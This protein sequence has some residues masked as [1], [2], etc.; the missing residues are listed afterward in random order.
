MANDMVVKVG[1]SLFDLPDLGSRLRAWLTGQPTR[2]MVLVPGG[3]AAAD[4]VRMAAVSDALHETTC[5]WLALSAMEFMGHILLA[6]LQLRGALIEDIAGRED[7]WRQGLIPVLGMYGFASK[8][9]LS[10]DHLPHSWAATSDSFAARAAVVAD[11]PELVLL[12]SCDLP[13]GCD[14]VEAARRGIVDALFPDLLAKAGARLRATVVN[15]RQWSAPA[16]SAIVPPGN[17][18]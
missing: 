16:S 7:A 3:G 11:I 14:W 5:H 9:E 10:S 12:K 17:T 1:G 13:T 2:R 6:R 18:L 8:D 4:L 15:L